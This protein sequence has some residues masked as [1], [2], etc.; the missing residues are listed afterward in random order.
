MW[1]ERYKVDVP[2]GT[3]GDWSVER[4]TVSDD[5]AKF[6]SL[7]AINPSSGGRGAVRAGSY[8]RL[9]RKGAWNPIMSDTS[10]EIMDH[11]EFMRIASGTVLVAGL[12]LGMVLQGLLNKPEVTRVT[13]VEKSPDVIALVKA[14]Y[15]TK[16]GTDRFDIICDDIFTYKPPKGQKWDFAWFDIWD[17]ICVDNRKEFSKLRR[18]FGRRCPSKYFWCEKQIELEHARQKRNKKRYHY[19]F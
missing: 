8:T 4:F 3:S 2:E 7:R 1:Y 14:H 12:G 9:K 5:D 16:F 18:K 10:D 11:Y 17:N 19:Y 6:A 15:E 13:V